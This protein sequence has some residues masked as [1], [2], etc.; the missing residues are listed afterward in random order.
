MQKKWYVFSRA[1]LGLFTLTSFSTIT[2]TTK[3]APS[4]DTYVPGE[5]IVQWAVAPQAANSN[6]TIADTISLVPVNDVAEAIKEFQTDSR[7]AR[8]EPNYKRYLAATP[9]DEFYLSQVHLD[10]SNDHDIDAELAWDTTTG[11]RT[12]I[13]AVIDSGVDI[14][15]PDL[16]DNIWTNPNE[17]A[18]NGVDDDDNGYIDDVHGWDFIEDDNDPTPRPTGSSFSDIYVLHGTHVSGIIGAI[19]NNTVG[20]SGVNW[21]VSIMPLRIFDDDG[22]TTTFS[23]IDAMA[24]AQANGAKVMNMSYGGYFYSALED[25]AMQAAYEDGVISVAAAGNDALNLDVIPSYPVCY[26]NVIGVG[27]VDDNDDTTVFTNYGN[28][29]VDLAAPGQNILSTYYS[30][31]PTNGFTDDYGYLS[32][33]SMSTPV[34]SGVA[35]L[36]LASIS[37]TTPAKLAIA[38]IDTTDPIGDSE[39][40]SGRVNAAAAIAKAISTGPDPIIIKAFTNKQRTKKIL[41]NQRTAEQSPYFTWTEPNSTEAIS[42]YY[43]YFGKERADPEIDGTLQTATF[44]A[45]TGVTGNETVYRLRI[46]AVDTLEQT[47]D[48]SSFIYLVDTKVARPLL[49]S[50]KRAQGLMEIRWHKP[51]AEHVKGYYLYRSRTAA[52]PFRKAT[53]RLIKRRSYIDESVKPQRRYY[54]KV[55]AVDDLGNRSVLSPAKRSPL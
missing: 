51:K 24:Y 2:P 12:V 11:S 53:T 22:M 38:L 26:D 14:T 34:V 52:G 36:V 23:T 15:H 9:N 7:V 25:E 41:S 6:L 33:T 3:E 10:Q 1:T 54:Y 45:P 18:G 19:G 32:G 30:N 55:R 44:F 42:G 8:V 16:V 40:G 37:D 28:I 27:A 17:V 29:C 4:A 13:I 46:K 48:L 39:L 35:G 5:V 21:E 43:V 47:S 50:I 20:V 31:D 49:Q